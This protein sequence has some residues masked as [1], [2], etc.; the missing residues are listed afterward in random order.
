MC[1]L[2]PDAQTVGQTDAQGQ[3]G[4]LHGDRIDELVTTGEAIPRFV[5][6]ERGMRRVTQP[7][8]PDG[9]DE[10][11]RRAPLRLPGAARRAEPL[12]NEPW[13]G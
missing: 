6:T 4:V 3:A 1:L 7:R 10:V 5:L 8:Q 11:L 12:P 2:T 13:L 9:S